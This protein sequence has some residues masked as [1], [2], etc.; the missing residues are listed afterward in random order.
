[1][2]TLASLAGALA[3]VVWALQERAEDRDAG[4][5]PRP[6]RAEAPSLE[7]APP[8]TEADLPRL[9]RPPTLDGRRAEAVWEEAE[10]LSALVRY[11]GEEAERRTTAWA[12]HDEE[13][14]YLAVRCAEP[15][16]EALRA[17][18]EPG[19]DEP[20]TPRVLKDDSLEVFV[21]VRP[22]NPFYT[23]FIGTAGGAQWDGRFEDTPVEAGLG[24]RPG[25]SWDGA[26]RLGAHTAG[27]HWQV[28]IKIPWSTLDLEGAPTGRTIRFNLVRNWRV[29]TPEQRIW[30]WSPTMASN[31]HITSRF[32]KLHV[33]AP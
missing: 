7:E 30:Q 10:R 3:L 17:R 25:A 9:S 12:A 31:N 16:M 11:D 5:A 8:V 2:L 22:E 4:D 27:D 19:E 28:E 33:R 1:L 13:A 23:Q 24:N 20:E 21:D 26:W 32:G 29:Q 14:L 18:V 6:D 15:K